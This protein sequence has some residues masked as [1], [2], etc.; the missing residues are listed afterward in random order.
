MHTAGS[1]NPLNLHRH[2][3]RDTVT[4]TENRLG[5]VSKI[6]LALTKMIYLL[7]GVLLCTT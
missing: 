7:K 6:I 4:F 2:D 5:A 3:K 1:V